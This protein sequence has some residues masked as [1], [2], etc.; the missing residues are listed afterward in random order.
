MY[1]ILK[2]GII[3]AKLNLYDAKILK[4]TF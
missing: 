1:R 3:Q 2:F 4:P